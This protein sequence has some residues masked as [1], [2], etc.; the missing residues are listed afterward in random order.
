[1][2]HT[3]VAHILE[4]GHDNP[5]PPAPASHLQKAWD[6]CR[7]EATADTLLGN[8]QDGPSRAR[9]LAAST[10]ESGAWLNAPPITSLGLRMDDS[11]IRVAVGLR[12]GTTLCRPHSCHHCGTEVD[13]QGTHGLSCKKSE[14]RH[15]G[16]AMQHSMTLYKG[17]SPQHI[18]LLGWN[19]LEFAALMGNA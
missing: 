14:G 18:S 8:A 19:H 7:V 4:R 9:L 10:K 5:P 11:T 13:H 15:H 12:L 2:H 17:P 6:S 16:I 1:M 3:E